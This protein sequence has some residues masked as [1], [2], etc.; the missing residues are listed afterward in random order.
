MLVVKLG[1][2]ASSSPSFS[3][4]QTQDLAVWAS[5]V[6][7]LGEKSAVGVVICGQTRARASV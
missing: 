2:V 4:E 3:L 7:S 1:G 6:R 5:L